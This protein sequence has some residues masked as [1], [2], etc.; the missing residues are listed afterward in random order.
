MTKYV[1]PKL[2]SKKALSEFATILGFSKYLVISKQIEESN[3]REN[4]NIL[5]DTF[6]AFLGAL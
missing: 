2:V 4:T 1:K 6:E 3:G 5:E